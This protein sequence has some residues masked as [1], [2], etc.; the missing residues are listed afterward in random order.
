MKNLRCA[1]SFV[2]HGMMLFV[3]GLDLPSA[4]ES[5]ESKASRRRRATSVGAIE[6]APDAV[7]GRSTKRLAL[8]RDMTFGEIF[9]RFPK[10]RMLLMRGLQDVDSVRGANLTLDE[11][12]RRFK[13]GWA[14]DAC[15]CTLN[16]CLV[17]LENADRQVVGDPALVDYDLFHGLKNLPSPET[18]RPVVNVTMDKN[19]QG[20]DCDGG[21]PYLRWVLSDGL[22]AVQLQ[23]NGPPIEMLTCFQRVAGMSCEKIFD[24]GFLDLVVDGRRH[25][26]DQVHLHSFGYENHSKANPDEK[27]S[28]LMYG[29]RMWVNLACPGKRVLWILD[30]SKMSM[31][32]WAKRQTIRHGWDTAARCLFFTTI[33]DR[34]NRVGVRPKA[35]DGF[36]DQQVIDFI[37]TEW[38][39]TIQG[40][41][42]MHTECWLAIGPDSE[43]RYVG[44]PSR[45]IWFADEVASWKEGNQKEKKS[46]SL[47]TFSAQE[48]G[49]LMIGIGSTREG[50]LAELNAA[51]EGQK[52]PRKRQS[53]RYERVERR[54]PRLEA[55]GHETLGEIAA[56]APLFLESLKT[57]F[58][59]MR[60]RPHN[61]GVC[62][63]LDQ[64][65]ISCPMV[66]AGDYEMTPRFL[67]HWLHQ[68][69]LDGQIFHVS[70]VDLSPAVVFKRWDSKEF[71]YLIDAAQWIDHCDDSTMLDRLSAKCTHMLRVMLDQS[72]P[73]TGLIACRDIFP[74]WPPM[75]SGRTGVTYPAMAN[76]LWYEAIRWWEGLAARLGEQA[77]APAYGVRQ[78]R[79]AAALPN[80]IW[81]ERRA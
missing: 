31:Q 64:T 80:C 72:D 19:R 40:P 76:G 54:L 70:D 61:G 16:N 47:H 77:L 69:A 62:G 45:C 5:G 32:S 79:F 68:V 71:T 24:E 81:T 14:F 36:T 44:K 53:E 52:L 18:T 39:E 3:L 63:G 57:G 38:P 33:D 60:S 21:L 20:L 7:V 30:D 46:G 26:F 17:L 23:Q 41:K 42:P 65:I 67:E 50:A 27:S 15:M 4:A 37:G 56:M 74:D 66:R 2:A 13:Y 1:M 78:T 9:R 49:C 58:A 55:P 12:A 35:Y 51:R 48:S 25:R 43:T 34:P 6:K 22:N 8:R 11:Y 29:D 28:L 10:A 75:E 59:L 73:K